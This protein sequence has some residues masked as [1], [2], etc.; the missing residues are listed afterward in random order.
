MNSLDPISFE[1]LKEDKDCE[2]AH[3]SLSPVS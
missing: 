1:V 3:E 2:D